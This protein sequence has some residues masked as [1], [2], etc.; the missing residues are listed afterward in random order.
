MGWGGV[1][2]EME[3]EDQGLKIENYPA[4]FLAKSF[5]RNRPTGGSQT[6]MTKV[7]ID[8]FRRSFHF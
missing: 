4:I 2:Q 8:R 3:G 1:G 6:E 5:D 7:G